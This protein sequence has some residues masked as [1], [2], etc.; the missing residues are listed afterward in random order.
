MSYQH[1]IDRMPQKGDMCLIDEVLDANETSITC[2]AKDHSTAAY[3]LRIDGQ[4]MKAS[5]VEL[6]AQAAAAHA[7]LFGIGDHHAG[8]LLA[9]HNVEVS[10]GDA[11][12]AESPLNATA[13]RLHFDDT[14]ARYRFAVNTETEEI[15]SGEAMLMMQAVPP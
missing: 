7:S 8:M 4:L 6:G 12:L 13:E 5:L 2:R 15:L 1:A 3:P 9:L 11:D 14:G 10:Q